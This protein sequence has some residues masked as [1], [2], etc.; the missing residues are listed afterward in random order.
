MTP[1]PIKR[2][3]GH[4]CFKHAT[5]LRPRFFECGKCKVTW[6]KRNRMWWEWLDMEGPCGARGWSD[7][8]STEW[9]SDTECGRCFD[10]RRL[11]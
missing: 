8:T 7:D 9:A 6:W 3:E 4:D 2:I 10:A 5:N 1:T 11:N